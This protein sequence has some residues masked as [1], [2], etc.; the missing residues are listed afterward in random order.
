MILTLV[1]RTEMSGS[2]GL[3]LTV[4]HISVVVGSQVMILKYLMVGQLKV[5]VNTPLEMCGSH[6][7]VSESCRMNF[8]RDYIELDPNVCVCTL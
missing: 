1:H 6:V 2:V 8:L 4:S 3:V 5:R 7:C